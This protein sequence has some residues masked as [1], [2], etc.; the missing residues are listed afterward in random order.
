ML[1]QAR[2]CLQKNFQQTENIRLMLA[3]CL[4]NLYTNNLKNT[5][6]SFKV[7]LLQKA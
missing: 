6:K 4:F 7:M 3:L 1:Q 5:Y 2:F